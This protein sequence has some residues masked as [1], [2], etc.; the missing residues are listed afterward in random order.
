MDITVLII[1]RN[2][3]K[4]LQRAIVSVR[5]Q[6]F[7]GNIKILIGIDDCQST[8]AFLKEN[9]LIDQTISW[10]YSER[11]K[12]DLSG[13]SRLG[14]LRNLSVEYANT[15]WVSFLDDDNELEI[16]HYSE[17]MRCAS[18]NN[19]EAGDMYSE[20]IG[21]LHHS[22]IKYHHLNTGLFRNSNSPVVLC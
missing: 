11:L 9:Y 20:V 8:L 15:E 14:Y 10:F 2:R 13:P 22:I 21:R 18:L 4:L 3:S 17:L 16:F 12:D 5:N 1:T 19:S 6:C 7:C